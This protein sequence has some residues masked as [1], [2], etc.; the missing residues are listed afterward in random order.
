MF[1]EAQEW[2]GWDGPVIKGV[3]PVPSYWMLKYDVSYHGFIYTLEGGHIVTPGDWIV[4][5]IAG[6]QWPMKPKI[7]AQ[8][9]EKVEEPIDGDIDY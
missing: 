5:G 2:L 7:F 8:T 1:V 4:T 6:E 9:Y 3:I